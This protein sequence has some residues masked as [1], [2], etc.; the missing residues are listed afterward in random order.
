MYKDDYFLIPPISKE[1]YSIILITAITSLFLGIFSLTIGFMGFVITVFLLYFF[2][3]P[4]RIVPKADRL[5]LSPADGRITDIE[6][7]D[8]FPSEL[9]LEGEELIK[10][11][12][13][14]SVFDVHVNR[15][16]VSGIVRSLLYIPGIFSN[17][18]F[19][20]ASF[21]NER[22]IVLIEDE[23]K[24]KVV[25]VQISGLIARRVICRLSNDQHVEQGERF[26]VIKFGSR[27]DLYVPRSYSLTVIKGQI[28][29]G[30]ETILARKDS[31]V[32][33]S[34]DFKII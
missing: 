34:K 8:Y 1:G 21:K 18:F 17:A 19:D 32:F 26:G 27:V 10:I 25:V 23:D 9:A 2:R 20:K 5:L 33:L 4:V 6:F 29:V 7:V 24:E 12:I 13:F 22:Q 16:P 28:V 14:L 30:G 31:D 15:I 3:D 11:S